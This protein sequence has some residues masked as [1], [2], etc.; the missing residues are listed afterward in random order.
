[1][2]A[3]LRRPGARAAGAGT[4]RPAAGITSAFAA[5]GVNLT[6]PSGLN[7]RGQIAGFTTGA[8]PGARVPSPQP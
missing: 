3:R 1:M 4:P 7:S 6:V 2:A 8:L 5:P